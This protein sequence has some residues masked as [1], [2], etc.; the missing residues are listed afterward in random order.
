LII[1]GLQKVSLIDFPEKV[2][3][4]VFTRGCNFRCPYCHNPE[5]VDPNRYVS[6]L[7]EAS[8][9]S[10]L[11]TRADRLQGVVISGGEPTIHEDLTAFARRIRSLGYAIKLDTNG[12]SPGMLE[13]LVAQKLL[14]YVALDVKSPLRKYA[15]VA[16]VPTAADEVRRSIEI[17]IHSRV[18]H[19]IR[20]TYAEPLL[21]PADLSEIAEDVRGCNLLVLQAFRPGT[22][23]DPDTLALR[24]PSQGTLA[25]ARNRIESMGV[26]C[27]VR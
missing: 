1:G 4:V 10:F 8:V 14:D 25:D 22:I 27:L 23:L 24:P 19:E 7:V 21:C 26:R 15:E 18:P 17:L 6:P 11:E 16:R 9:F 3:A 2:A 5:L 13:R 12:S 20:T